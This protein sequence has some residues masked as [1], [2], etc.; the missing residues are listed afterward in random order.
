MEEYLRPFM[1]KVDGQRHCLRKVDCR[2]R[3]DPNPHC[4]T[5]D[6]MFK[7]TLQLLQVQVR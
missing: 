2:V 6:E 5:T 1:L 4:L 3:D 7:E